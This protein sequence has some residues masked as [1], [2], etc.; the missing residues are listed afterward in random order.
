MNLLWILA[1]SA[2]YQ[3]T[4]KIEDYNDLHHE[5]AISKLT[6]IEKS[7]FQIALVL[8]EITI[9]KN[10]MEGKLI[11]SNRLKETLKFLMCVTKL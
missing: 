6:S 10:G 3:E 1:Q 4:Q 2:N 11:K 7:T 5:Y 9:R 8:H